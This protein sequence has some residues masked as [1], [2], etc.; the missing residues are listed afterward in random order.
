MVDRAIVTAKI[1]QIERC[2]VRIQGKRPASLKIFM[3][4]QDCQDIVIFNLTRALQGCIDLAAHIVSDGGFGAAGSTNE[5]FYLLQE[6]GIITAELTENM[7]SAVGF[8]NLC[9]HE[10][11]RIDLERVF[12]IAGSGLT[13]VQEFVRMVVQR[14]T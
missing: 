4:D 11:G 12:E 8:R 6:Q 1:G 13:D 9:V 2:L 14:Y 5:F 3:K 7:V 10:Y